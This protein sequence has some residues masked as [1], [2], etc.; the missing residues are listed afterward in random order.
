MVGFLSR[1]EVFDGEGRDALHSFAALGE[2]RR[3]RRGQAL[4]EEGDASSHLV[5][6]RSGV[7]LL[8]RHRAE[9]TV[10]LD[11]VGQGTFLGLEGTAR[12]YEAVVHE[13]ANL[14]FVPRAALER[15]LVSHPRAA[16]AV[17]QLAG[18]QSERLA[19]RLTLVSMHGARSRL[20]CL[21]LDLAGRF[22]VRDSRGVILDLRLTHREMAAL[23]RGDPR[24]RERRHRGA[25]QAGGDPHREPA[26][27]PRR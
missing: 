14:F 27:H 7:V 8:R 5:V 21:F 13:D 18:G 2:L 10:C 26:R 9:H 23:I 20:A 16:L 22:G 24:D 25:P 17:L 6:V 11:V 4:W 1:L 15:W 12:A 19:S 3:V